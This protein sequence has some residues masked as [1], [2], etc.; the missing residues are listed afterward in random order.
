MNGRAQFEFRASLSDLDHGLELLHRSIENL[1]RETGRAEDDPALTLFE[2][3]LGEIAAN[4]LTHGRPHQGTRSP[5]DYV[6]RLRGTTVVATL[7]DGGPAV[8]EHLGRPMPDADS[9]AGRGL[10]IARS[11]LDDLGYERYG[12]V[13]RWRLVKTL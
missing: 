9:E 3:A 10:T 1:R 5:V 6:L 4:A 7:T 12:D 11:L 8:H 2:T 13:N